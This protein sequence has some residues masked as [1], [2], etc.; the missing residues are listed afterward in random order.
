MF[1][2]T[3][4]QQD[5][6]L[7]VSKKLRRPAWAGFKTAED[8]R[9]KIINV[10]HVKECNGMPIEVRFAYWLLIPKYTDNTRKISLYKYLPHI[11]TFQLTVTFYSSKNLW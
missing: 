3:E 1:T 5:G 8:G 11:L 7:L 6:L 9:T 10:G 4:I 2:F